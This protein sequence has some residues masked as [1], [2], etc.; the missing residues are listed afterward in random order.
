MALSE[1]VSV[2]GA[3]EDGLGGP[4]KDMWNRRSPEQQPLQTTAVTIPAPGLRSRYHHL[5]VMA[6]LSGLAFLFPYP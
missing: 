6:S 5:V 2:A 4:P 3:M 1:W